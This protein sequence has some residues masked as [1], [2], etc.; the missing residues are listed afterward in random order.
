MQSQF[1]NVVDFDYGVIGD[2]PLVS[3]IPLL[4]NWI[5]VLGIHQASG[6][7]VHQV[8]QRRW[9][10]R[11]W[12]NA[13]APV[14]QRDSCAGDFGVR[15]T[16]AEN[17]LI[18][19][20]IGLLDHEERN[21]LKHVSIVQAIAAANDVLSRASKVIGKPYAR[22]EVFVVVMSQRRCE[23]TAD[24]QQLLVSA[25]LAD[26]AGSDQVEIFIPAHTQI[27]GQPSW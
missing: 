8:R 26:G 21:V 13:I 20:R 18:D 6:C 19:R 23:R 3:G 17:A 25:A 16:D 1:V 11:E 22:T 24:G 5:A 10:R 9:N 27:Q 2:R 15:R 12:V 14:A 7:S 4:R